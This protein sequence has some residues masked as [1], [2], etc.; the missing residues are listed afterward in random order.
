MKSII[1]LL[2]ASL[3]GAISSCAPHADVPTPPLPA[4]PPKAAA[5]APAVSRIRETISDADKQAAAVRDAARESATA[6]TRARE[7]AGRLAANKTATAA[8]LTGLWQAL[9]SVEARNLFLEGETA[10]LTTRI[11][12]LRDEASRLQETATARDLEA[13]QLRG[14]NDGLMATTAHYATALRTAQAD[15]STQRTR[16]DKLKGEINL[17][18]IALGIAAILIVLWAALRFLTPPRLL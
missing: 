5:V 4:P 16:A 7:E 10:R 12:T 2:I 3:L 18:R 6:S 9:Q 1:P 17:H 11:T 15:A 13:T 8:E 14:A